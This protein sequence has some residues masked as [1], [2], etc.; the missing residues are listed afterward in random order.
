M[1]SEE[2]RK[3][4]SAFGMTALFAIF[5]LGTSKPAYAGPPIITDDPEPVDYGHWEVYGFS[6]GAHGSSDTSG[7]GPSVEVNYGAL[8]N[9]QLHAIMGF[10]FDGTSGRHLQMGISDTELGVKYRF[11]NPGEDDWWPQIGMFPLVELPSGNASR[12]LGAGYTQEFLPIWVQKDFGKW[13]TYGG[14]W[15][16][17]GPG[18]KNYWF[19]GWLL[20][21]QITD[22]LALGVEVFHQTPAMVGRDA[23][24]GFNVGGA[25]DFT[26][27]YH[28]LFSAG[29]GGLL[30]AVN[31]AT[32]QNP[33][34]YYLGFQ[35]TF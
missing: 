9:L 15:I 18:N 11:I 3:R 30:Y 21:R 33:F 7:L 34:T 26:E 17:P 28:L 35:W 22:D 13:T 25:Y 2:T 29:Q 20:Q 6:A 32:V 24:S 4:R 10:A 27:H 1:K 23:S 31:G 5:V 8:P 12:G 16:N 14:Y 19:A